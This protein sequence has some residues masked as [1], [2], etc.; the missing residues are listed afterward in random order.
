[1]RPLTHC[2]RTSGVVQHLEGC[3]EGDLEVMEDIQKLGDL[4]FE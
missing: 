2:I 1:M 4:A 3:S